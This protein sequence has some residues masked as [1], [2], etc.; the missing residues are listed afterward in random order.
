[1]LWQILHTS[2]HQQ[3]KYKLC[4]LCFQQYLHTAGDQRVGKDV[5]LCWFEKP[6][7]HITLSNCKNTILCFLEYHPVAPTLKQ[8]SAAYRMLCPNTKHGLL[9]LVVLNVALV[10]FVCRITFPQLICRTIIQGNKGSPDSTLNSSCESCCLLDKGMAS[11][12]SAGTLPQTST[13]VL[14]MK[15]RNPRNCWR[16]SAF[17]LTQVRI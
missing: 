7:W 11:R 16:L 3:C 15:Y 2:Y 12:W 13:E 17:Y 6:R 5:F 8:L 14:L 4:Y 1:M 9:P 10:R